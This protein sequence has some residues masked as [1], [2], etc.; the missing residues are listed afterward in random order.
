MLRAMAK[1]KTLPKDFEAL[2]DAG[3]LDAIKA[4]FEQCDV[5]ARGGFYKH[6]ALAFPSFPDEL[7][8]WLV[9]RGTDVNAVDQWGRTALHIRASWRNARLDVLCEVGCDVNA[10]ASM[11]DGTPL[12]KAALAH[13]SRHVATLLAHGANADAKN[14][15]GQTPLEVALESCNNTDLEETAEI[16]RLLLAHGAQKSARAQAHLR[17]VGQRFQFHRA[18]MDAELAAT[19]SAA[20]AALDAIFDAT[21]VPVRRMHDGASNIVATSRTWQEQHRELWNLLVPSS[22]A[23][24]TVQGEVIRIAGRIGDELHRNGAVNWNDEYRRMAHALLAHVKTG[25]PLASAQLAELT[26][27][28]AALTRSA[29]GDTD[30]LAELAVAWVRLNPHPMPL[31]APDDAR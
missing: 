21:P 20:L 8:R 9:A 17:E 6:T 5:N 24:A 26:V 30:R 19:C 10:M 12:H 22:G 23:A 1:R 2:L 3:D 11:S 4:V 27:L 14:D 28:V 13:I 7:V 31:A 29:D 18:A 16:A 15:R 25:T